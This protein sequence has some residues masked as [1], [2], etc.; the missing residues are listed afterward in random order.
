MGLSG[1]YTLMSEFT[2]LAELYTKHLKKDRISMLKTGILSIGSRG[3]S[4]KLVLTMH[5]V[6]GKK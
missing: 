6:V 5:E 3:C 1:V 2:N 4:R